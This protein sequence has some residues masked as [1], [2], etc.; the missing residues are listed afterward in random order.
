LPALANWPAALDTLRL[1]NNQLGASAFASVA[2]SPAL[3][4]LSTLDLSGTGIAEPDVVALAEAALPLTSL[5]LSDN[6]LGTAAI[7]RLANSPGVAGLKRLAL[8]NTA[9]GSA[10]LDALLASPYLSTSLELTL[11]GELLGL[12]P[13]IWYDWT[14]AAIG[15]SWCGE[16]PE[17]VKQR[18][19]VVVEGKPAW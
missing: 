1:P 4:Q 11:D 10:G 6:P 15:A 17:H 18:F 12:Q 8:A 9:M 2:G 14:G 13:D 3:R 5:D 16:P 7:T 19:R